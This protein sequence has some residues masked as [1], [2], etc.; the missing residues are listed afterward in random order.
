MHAIHTGERAVRVRD[1]AAVHGV[2][3]EHAHGHCADRAALRRWDD[4][5]H[6]L[7]ARVRRSDRLGGA[8][9]AEEPTRIRQLDAR[10]SDLHER[11]ARHRPTVRVHAVR[12][13]DLKLEAQPVRRVLLLAL[14][15]LDTHRAS[16]MP[17]G[18]AVQLRRAAPRGGDRRAVEAT[19]HVPEERRASREAA[20]RHVDECP[21]VDR[22]AAR[23]E[24]THCHRLLVL[25]VHAR[26]A[27]VVTI[28]AHLDRHVSGSRGQRR[29]ALELAG[30]EQPRR[31]H[32]IGK[33][34]ARRGV[35]DEAVAVHR[36]ERAPKAHARHRM[37]AIHT[38][39]RA[40][41]VRDDVRIHC[42]ID[43]YSYALDAFLVRRGDTPDSVRV[44]QRACDWH[45]TEQTMHPGVARRVETVPADDYHCATFYRP[46]TWRG[47]THVHVRVLEAQTIGRVLLLV[48]CHFHPR[49]ALLLRRAH[50]RDLTRRDEGRLNNRSAKFAREVLQLCRALCKGATCH[51]CHSRSEGDGVRQDSN[52]GF[53]V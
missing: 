50:A 1:D 19:P 52:V 27:V 35:A 8:K 3:V 38:G 7:A 37:H 51:V 42:P 47:R 18:D 33:A 4:A 49:W 15:H 26:R 10:A 41:R 22:P 36:H 40:V 45:G 46:N 43:T 14:R 23:L 48:L 53:L 30:S 31:H 16:R 32:H 12:R 5:Q 6:K 25:E 34:A 20:A 39:E 29:D 11:A 24:R 13:D 2:I 28:R 17:R 44:V 21:A 9:L